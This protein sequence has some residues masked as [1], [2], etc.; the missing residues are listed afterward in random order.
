[1]FELVEPAPLPTPP[2]SRGPLAFAV[3]REEAAEAAA[4]AAVEAP[5]VVPST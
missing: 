1:M 5:V 3:G 4:A 2:A